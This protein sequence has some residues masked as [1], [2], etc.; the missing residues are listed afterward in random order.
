MITYN[1][2][3]KLEDITSP[4]YYEVN[5]VKVIIEELSNQYHLSIPN[6]GF[7]GTAL[8]QKELT[9]KLNELTN[10]LEKLINEPGVRE[11]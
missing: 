1:K 7:M 4:G 2:A 3:N 6:N 8:P 5:G 10:G 9:V 11:D